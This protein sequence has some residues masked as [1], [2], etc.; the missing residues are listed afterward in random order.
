MRLNMSRYSVCNLL[1]LLVL[2]TA[3]CGAEERKTVCVADSNQQMRVFIAE[4]ARISS[5]SGTDSVSF[6]LRIENGHPESL[7]IAFMSYDSCANKWETLSNGSKHEHTDAAQTHIISTVAIANRWH[8]ACVAP[9]SGSGQMYYSQ[10]VFYSPLGATSTDA[11]PAP[12]VS[13][14]AGGTSIGPGAFA[15]IVLFLL[16]IVTPLVIVFMIC[17]WG[18]SLARSCCA[19]HVVHRETQTRLAS[20]HSCVMQKMRA[21]R[22]RGFQLND[23]YGNPYCGESPHYL[24]KA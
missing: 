6:S 12:P 3:S 21:P 4:Y 10:P 20:P 5:H 22:L 11:P 24:N 1:A 13:S 14:A 2:S 16:W 23:Q 18:V 17:W 19:P 15:L 7:A 8:L 9:S